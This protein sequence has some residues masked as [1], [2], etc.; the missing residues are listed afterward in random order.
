ML[1]N[2]GSAT[3]GEGPR[4]LGD[5]W[6]LTATAMVIVIL[7]IIAKWR[8]GKFGVDDVLMGFALVSKHFFLIFTQICNCIRLHERYQHGL[9]GPAFVFPN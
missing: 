1:V 2:R 9:D 8:I 5:V 7:R 4:L 6:G 3:F